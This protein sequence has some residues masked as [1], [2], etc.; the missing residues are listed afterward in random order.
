MTR[1]CSSAATDANDSFRQDLTFTRHEANG[2]HWSEPDGDT[3][4]SECPLTGSQGVKLPNRIVPSPDVGER[5]RGQ[6]NGWLWRSRTFPL[7]A[8]IGR[9]VQR[10]GRIANCTG[11]FVAGECPQFRASIGRRNRSPQ[12]TSASQAR[13]FAGLTC[14]WPEPSPKS[15]TCWLGRQDSNLRMPVPKTGAL[16]LG[17]A[18]P[19]RRA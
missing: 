16:P 10:T 9:K 18:P 8:P 17:D 13:R 5:A 11:H 15:M 6:T 3:R 7:G 2:W 1:C 4:A 14:H 19:V 12:C